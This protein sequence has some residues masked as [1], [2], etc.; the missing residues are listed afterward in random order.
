F[1][2]GGVLWQSD[3]RQEAVTRSESRHLEDVVARTVALVADLE[4]T[5][6]SPA[7]SVPSGWQPIE[8]AP[9][10]GT[11]VLSYCTGFD[12]SYGPHHAPGFAIIAWD[13]EFGFWQVMPDSAYEIG[14][15]PTH[16]TPLPA[17]PT[18][19]GGDA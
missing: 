19:G 6:P 12:V 5:S 13:D 11:W 16:W 2:L 8:T 14:A 3:G 15:T 1:A 9:K 17:A 4:R 18:A 7:Q 10:D